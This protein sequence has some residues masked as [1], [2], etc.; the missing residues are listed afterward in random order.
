MIARPLPTRDLVAPLGL[1]FTDGLDG[2]TILDGLSVR[3]WPEG[4]AERTVAATINGAGIAGFLRLPGVRFNPANPFAGSTQTFIVE[5]R[6]A[7]GRFQTGRV[8]AE[9]PVAGVKRV[10]MRSAP[11]RTVAPGRLA[12]RAELWDAINARAAAFAILTVK[13]A[14]N[15]STVVA[16]GMA[17]AAGRVLAVG[18][19]PTP[20][21]AGAGDKPLWNA[22]RPVTLE[23]LYEPTAPS[24]PRLDRVATTPA[25]A[26]KTRGP[27]VLFAP[28]D[29]A[30]RQPV[31]FLSTGD[32][33]SRLLITS[34]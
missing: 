1:I 9:A 12:F 11:T 22:S 31:V 20:K 17:D 15:G 30:D 26:W 19:W 23:I 6:D 8:S 3:A 24:V 32:T 21:L 28:A 4:R 34:P 33:L 18:D 16:T 2:R 7:M 25:R 14:G 29:L 10:V 5:V 27:D 13:L